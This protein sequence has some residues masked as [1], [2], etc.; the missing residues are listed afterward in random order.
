MYE[1]ASPRVVTV[2]I[3]VLTGQACGEAAEPPSAAAIRDSAGVTIV[4][5]EHPRWTVGEAWRISPEPA[6]DIGVGS[7]DA[8]QE[9][10]RV[11]PLHLRKLLS[12]FFPCFR[13]TPRPWFP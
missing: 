4:E 5:N 3:L 10:Y 12:N 1:P 9:L 2:A 7:G 6:L 8:D 13:Q 11:R